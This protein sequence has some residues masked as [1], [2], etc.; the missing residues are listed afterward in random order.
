[1]TSIPAFAPASDFV[2]AQINAA[3]WPELEPLYATLVGREL[4]CVKCLQRLIVDRS[5]LDAAANEAST[6]LYV[7]MTCHTD[8]PEHANAYKEF[9]TNVEPELKRVGFELDRKIVS[10]P[11]ASELP[12]DRYGV[13]LRG[14]RAAVALFRP[15]N[16]D[17]QTQE[18]NLQQEY[19][20]IIGAM[21]VEF[22]GQTRTIPQMG[23]Y[24]ESADRAVREQAWRAVTER[25]LTDAERIEAIFDQLVSL[26]TQIA[27][28]A[29]FANYRD[30][31]MQARRRF[32]YGPAECGAFA[33]GVC[34]SVVPASRRMMAERGAKLG[35]GTPRPWD[36]EVDVHGRGPLRPFIDGNDLFDRS[37]KLFEK[38]D[39][40]LGEL[41][42]SLR[43]GGHL[44][45]ESRPG[46]GPGGYQATRDRTRLPF[47]FMNAAGL[48]RDVETMVH[49]A[50]HAFHALL[51]RADP[52]LAYR[53]EIPIEF[54]EVASMSMELT[55]HPHLGAF[56]SPEDA[57]RA[58]RVH[59]TGI[60]TI[61][62]WI[63]TIDRF[64]DWIYT[65]P[66]HTRQERKDYWVSLIASFGPG[67]D[68]S[69][70]RQQQ[71]LVWHRQPHLFTSP[72]YYIEYGIAQL[73]SIELYGNF[74]RDSKGALAKYRDA[75]KLGGSRALPELFAA[76]GITFDF[77]PA[78][79]KRT[80]SAVEQDLAALPA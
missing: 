16:V 6:N 9:V 66:S 58:R 35:V 10:S 28:N 21:T 12:D 34:E 30:Y 67:L 46:K 33:A 5:E 69:G 18:A 70:L 40:T 65:N 53:S 79:I 75:L 60:A 26:R 48:Q 3:S 23:R 77:S 41:F 61:L 2:P 24:Q 71:E 31:A 74:K 32:D 72:F 20:T 13:L 68:W 39:P 15:E 57:A 62:P 8:Q 1:M 19:Q 43:H 56:Y 11:Y 4:H 73:G 45:L 49:E 29:G 22:D 27:V 55:A 52:I 14:L 64:Q 44:D 36:T 78:A 25:R 42:A 7:S 80:W 76:A 38:M 50:G 63:A 37:L 17:L 51:S 54:C 59:L 47:I